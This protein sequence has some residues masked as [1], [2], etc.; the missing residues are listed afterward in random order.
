MKSIKTNVPGFSLIE[1]SLA[2]LIIGVIAGLAIP[3]MRTIIKYQRTQ[4]SESNMSFVKD[5]LVGYL[6]H[7]RKLPCPCPDDTGV[8]ADSCDYR[9]AVGYVPYR[10]LQISQSKASGADGKI[11]IY[12]VEPELTES[13]S[14]FS[15]KPEQDDELVLLPEEDEKAA[16]NRSLCALD[17]SDKFLKVKNRNHAT[18]AEQSD[19]DFIAFVLY[20]VAALDGAPINFQSGEFTTH[21]DAKILWVTRNTLMSAYLKRP[22]VV[23]E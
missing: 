10:T 13:F 4:K 11:M 19:H 5:A 8:A 20:D 1:I 6:G 16:S 21:D 22:C 9:N 14:S 2:L 18:L 12:G 3:T 7:N 17:A 23:G 15:I